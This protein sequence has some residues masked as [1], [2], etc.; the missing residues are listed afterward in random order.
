MGGGGVLTG[1]YGTYNSE[2]TAWLLNAECLHYLEHINNALCLATLNG[3]D[4][5]TEHSTPA[6]CI[7]VCSVEKET[8]KYISIDIS[9][10]CPIRV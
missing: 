10:N 6:H 5:R 9:S 4:E 8:I 2:H 3:T 7:T 1:H